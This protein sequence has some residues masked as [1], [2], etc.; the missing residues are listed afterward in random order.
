MGRR[1]RPNPRRAGVKTK[2]ASGWVR[3]NRLGRLNEILHKLTNTVEA[4]NLTD[5]DLVRLVLE[6]IRDGRDPRDW[7]GIRGKDGPRPTARHSDVWVA[8]YFLKLRELEARKLEKTHRAMIHDD[9]G[10]SDSSIRGIIKAQRVRAKD[11]LVDP[12]LTWE[13][14]TLEA[15]RAVMLYWL[16][17]ERAD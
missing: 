14:K 3:E 2:A 17:V 4:L 10:L 5:R 12:A 7:F 13:T 16:S 6:R 15:V 11:L 8:A 1:A 9:T